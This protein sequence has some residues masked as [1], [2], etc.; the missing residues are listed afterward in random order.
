M[1]KQE[2]HLVDS[3]FSVNLGKRIA[4]LAEMVGGKENLAKKSGVSLSNIY[5]YINGE[6]AIPVITLAAM[7]SATEAKLDWL[8][9]GLDENSKVV[10]KNYRQIENS[11]PEFNSTKF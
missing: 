10:S 1:K 6:R 8:I 5:R 4:Q 7:A 2:S 3:S 11:I 9:F